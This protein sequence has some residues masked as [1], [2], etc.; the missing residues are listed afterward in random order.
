MNEPE[1]FDAF[2][3]LVEPLPPPPLSPDTLRRGARRRQAKLAGSG[4]VAAAAV[5]GLALL[6]LPSGPDRVVPAERPT[7]P[8]TAP[9]TPGPTPPAPT[10][11]PPTPTPTPAPPST[12][13]SERAI[14]E[15]PPMLGP[16]PEVTGDPVRP[17][18]VLQG[19]GLGLVS[20]S[21]SNRMQLFGEADPAVLQA[22]LARSLGPGTP[23][24]QPDC[25]ASV[26]TVSYGGLQILL[27][28]GRFAGW[29]LTGPGPRVTTGVGL[30]PG[31]TLAELRADLTP[32]EVTETTLGT[33]WTAGSL[34]GLLDGSTDDSRVTSVW[35]GR[36]CL[37]R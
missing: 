26:T 20:G 12:S 36:V 5:A 16:G 31:S 13:P 1:L 37:H 7:T 25:G 8:V 34:S 21:G 24:A 30:G 9:P 33:E 28:D 35:A 11:S 19:D 32:L 22:A 2:D 27:E 14:V 23:S 17:T 18:V 3:R 10:T 15:A 4:A 6:V 29:S